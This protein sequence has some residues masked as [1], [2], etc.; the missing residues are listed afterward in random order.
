M[1]PVEKDMNDTRPS[2]CY[3]LFADYVKCQ[4]RNYTRRERTICY[5]I[6]KMRKEYIYI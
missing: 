4:V 3:E 2:P 1:A 6:W 5:R